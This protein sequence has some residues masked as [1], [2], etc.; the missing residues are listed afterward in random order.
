MHDVTVRDGTTIRVR[1]YQPVGGPPEGGSPLVMMYHEGGWSMGDLTDEDMNCR[2][3]VRDLG[4]VAVNV[5]YR[6]IFFP[7]PTNPPFFFFQS[8]MGIHAE[9]D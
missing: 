2:M 3:F 6:Y 4:V 8:C 5:E 1:V 7:L 9:Y